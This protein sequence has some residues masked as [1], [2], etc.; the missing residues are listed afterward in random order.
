MKWWDKLSPAA[1]GAIWTMAGDQAQK[2]GMGGL[3]SIRDQ[4]PQD[5]RTQAFLC[6]AYLELYE[7]ILGVA[8]DLASVPGITLK[9]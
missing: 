2:T 6:W 5:L 8:M 3:I 7:T 1:R 9:K 4:W